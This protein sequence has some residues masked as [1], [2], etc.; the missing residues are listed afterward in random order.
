MIKTLPRSLSSWPNWLDRSFAGNPPSINQTSDSPLESSPPVS[1]KTCSLELG[2]VSW[3]H[4]G[5]CSGTRGSLAPCLGVQYGP[6]GPVI[7]GP[8]MGPEMGMVTRVVTSNL[9]IS[10]ISYNCITH[11]SNCMAIWKCIIFYHTKPCNA[12]IHYILCM[13]PISFW[14]GF[15][16]VCL[17][18][19]GHRKHQNHVVE[20]II[21]T[22]NLATTWR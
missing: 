9:L 12:T 3:N 14:S 20:K 11:Q 17:K 21:S 4:L 8:M 22:I 10:I 5:W 13:P 7:V 6:V 1:G 15:N 19:E 2:M 18:I 16:W